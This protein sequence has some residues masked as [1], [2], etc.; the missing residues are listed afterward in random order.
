[1]SKR[2]WVNLSEEQVLRIKGHFELEL[3]KVKR[4]PKGTPAYRNMCMFTS[5]VEAMTRRVAYLVEADRQLGAS[6]HEPPDV[7]DERGQAVCP[8]PGRRRVLGVA[9]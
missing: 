9:G 2:F 8:R 4:G 3:G 1:M 7:P 6:I 5:I